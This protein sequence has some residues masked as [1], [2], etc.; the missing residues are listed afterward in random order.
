MDDDDDYD[1]DDEEESSDDEKEDLGTDDNEFYDIDGESSD[2]SPKSTMRQTD[3]FDTSFCSFVHN[4]PGGT[5][6][7]RG[8][9][10][11]YLVLQKRVRNDSVDSEESEEKQREAIDIDAVDM[12]SK[13]VYH[14]QE[15]KEEDLQKRKEKKDF[16]RRGYGEETE[17]HKTYFHNTYDTYHKEQSHRILQEAVKLEDEYLDSTQDSLGLELLNGDERRR[18]WGRLIRAPLKRK[19]HVLLDYCSA[20]CGG[21]NGCFKGDGDDDS[22]NLPDETKGRITRQKV[23]RGWSARAAPGCHAAARKARWGGL[24]PDLSERVSS[25]EKRHD[26]RERETR[27]DHAQQMFPFPT[28]T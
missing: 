5:S 6:R 8:E 24:W 18:G 14:A 10:F 21:T 7:K 26:E 4:F 19:G 1:D 22:N 17:F 3:V 25:V 9:K 11:S 13:S 16:D 20:G 28:K 2:P 12:L 15:L 27:D 23:S